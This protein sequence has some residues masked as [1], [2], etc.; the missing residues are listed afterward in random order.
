MA[1]DPVMQ[2]YS[3][4]P[5]ATVSPIFKP[6]RVSGSIR[7][8]ML[9]PVLIK[10]T[11]RRGLNVIPARFALID[12]NVNHGS[13]MPL[14]CSSVEALT[15]GMA[16][17]TSV[18]PTC[19]KAVHVHGFSINGITIT[20]SFF[21]IQNAEITLMPNQ[22][23]QYVYSIGINIQPPD[24]TEISGILNSP[25]RQARRRIQR[26]MRHHLGC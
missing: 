16:S 1:S 12:A 8:V 17:N 14:V 5:L 3:T 7:I 25:P 23:A 4:A 9:N 21:N 22:S 15:Y 19:T 18:R 6:S 2:R 26:T 20:N 10:F 11:H 13:F 24:Y